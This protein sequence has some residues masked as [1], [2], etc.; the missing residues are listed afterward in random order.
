[1]G[2]SIQ[3]FSSEADSHFKF[4]GRYPWA[5][6]DT[7]RI[8]GDVVHITPNELIFFTP[9]AFLGKPMISILQ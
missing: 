4:S 7:L 6:E 5:I 9:E 3:L 2:E 8:Y 1:M